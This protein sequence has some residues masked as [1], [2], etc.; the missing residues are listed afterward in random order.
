M[1]LLL[2]LPRMAFVLPVPWLVEIAE[3][4]RRTCFVQPLPEAPAGSAARHDHAGGGG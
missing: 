2:L 1:E 4:L 3:P